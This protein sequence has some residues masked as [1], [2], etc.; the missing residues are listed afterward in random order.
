[1]VFICLLWFQILSNT[2]FIMLILLNFFYSEHFVITLCFVI[3]SD[4]FL[5]LFLPYAFPLP[6]VAILNKLL[7]YELLVS[8]IFLN[9]K[10]LHEAILTQCGMISYVFLVSW[11]EEHFHQLKYWLTFL[12]FFLYSFWTEFM[13]LF[14]SS[15]FGWGSISLMDHHP[16]GSCSRRDR[17]GVSCYSSNSPR[18]LIISFFHFISTSPKST[19]LSLFT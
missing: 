18:P 5:Y 17:V 11:Y 2:L 12:G 13:G 6:F 3:I 1:M 19:F 16:G 9:S 7:V 8:S 4:T 14:S 15:A 10:C